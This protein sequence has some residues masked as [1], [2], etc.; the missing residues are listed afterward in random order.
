[1]DGDTVLDVR[2][3]EA[4]KDASAPKKPS[5]PAEKWGKW[6]FT[7]WKGNYQ[8][9]TKDETVYAHF[10]KRLNRYKAVFYDAAGNA[11]SVQTVKHG[12]SAK[13]P[14]AP[15]KAPDAK[16]TYI[17]KGWDADTEN[18]TADTS[19]HP[20]YKAKARTY[21]VTFINGKKILS[22]QDVK[23]GSAAKAPKKPVKKADGKCVYKFAG[24]DADF[25]FITKDTV[26]HALF[27]AKENSSTDKTADQKKD[28]GKD[29]NK[30]TNKDTDK[31]NHTEKKNG[32]GTDKRNHDGT[33]SKNAGRDNNI[34]KNSGNNAGGADGTAAR[35]TDGAAAKPGNGRKTGS[36]GYTADSGS[37][38]SKTGIGTGKSNPRTGN[39]N[40]EMAGPKPS[41]QR[42]AA[43]ASA[44]KQEQ[45]AGSRA[46]SHADDRPAAGSRH[47]KETAN[48]NKIVPEKP[49]EKMN[50]DS[51]RKTADDTGSSEKERRNPGGFSILLLL[52]T[53]AVF[54]AAFAWLY[55]RAFRKY[56]VTGTVCDAD[57][58]PV[59]GAHILLSG[60]K[61]LETCT[62][63][64][65]KFCFDGIGKGIRQLE[66]WLDGDSAQLCM[67]IRVG[68]Q[69]A[70]KAFRIRSSHCTRIGHALE[71]DGYAVNVSL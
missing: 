13:A 22:V 68:E 11:A 36:G 26:I 38:G 9:V 44:Q 33:G 69:D 50:G 54:V 19:F 65:G 51:S 7:G 35:G 67:D 30:D 58:N 23:Y 60:E 40:P 42:P 52:F 45:Q 62:D 66:I 53:G 49:E 25:A 6:R 16:H 12:G 14:K 37:S 43:G 55:L 61:T 41:V 10:E 56:R 31:G 15:K 27:D 4:G 32:T 2:K 59:C 5:R 8:N 39:G 28:T 48:D 17:F 46:S 57:G 64:Q 21:T 70:G 34:K 63:G 3:V 20:V 18:I 24:W 47:E 29:I 71:K 1:M